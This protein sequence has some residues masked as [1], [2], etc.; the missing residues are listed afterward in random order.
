MTQKLLRLTLCLFSFFTIDQSAQAVTITGSHGIIQAET[1]TFKN[2]LFAPL[3]SF[4]KA[5]GMNEVWNPKTQIASV[6]STQLKFSFRAGSLYSSINGELRQMPAEAKMVNGR[7]HI[8]LQFG[9]D[10]FSGKIFQKPQL[11]QLQNIKAVKTPSKKGPLTVLLDPGHGG[12]DTGARGRRGTLEKNINLDIARRVQGQLQAH[13]I[14][15][16]MT[17]NTDRFITLP[18]RISIEK[19]FKPDLFVSIHTNAARNRSVHGI[20]IF[21][22]ANANAK[23]NG[24]CFKQNRS[25]SYQLARLVQSK[26]ITNI[27]K[28]SR[29]VKNARYFVLRNSDTP[30]IL[31]EVGFISHP[32]EEKS[33][34]QKDYRD[35]MAQA[36]A[37]AILACKKL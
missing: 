16:L 32:W 26:I 34:L 14:Q 12:P 33:L 30:A 5:Y 36:I 3:G 10:V 1:F 29:G 20:E 2:V 4:A 27:R 8:P 35:Q 25:K 11:L 31:I 37:Q 13:G 28:T 23:E 19:K 24:A 9:I 6:Q 21:Y 15:V 7:L 22:Y 18:C 17:R